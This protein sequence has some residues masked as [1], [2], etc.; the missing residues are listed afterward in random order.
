MVSI[1]YKLNP[2]L[3]HLHMQLV[4]TEF[5]NEQRI[6]ITKHI[7]LELQLKEYLKKN[8]TTIDVKKLLEFLDSSLK[9]GQP[10]TATIVDCQDMLGV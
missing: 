10:W 6:V 8:K 2:L 7:L 1:L 5:V 3:K 4:C 9:K